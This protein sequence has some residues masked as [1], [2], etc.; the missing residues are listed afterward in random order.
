MHV[1]LVYL[2]RAI[3][4]RAAASSS[5]GRSARLS[6]DEDFVESA[7]DQCRSCRRQSPDRYDLPR[8]LRRLQRSLRRRFS[9]LQLRVHRPRAT[10]SREMFGSWRVTVATLEGWLAPLEKVFN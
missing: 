1:M 5:T 9:S 10:V 7:C 2:P 4:P 6:R 3:L 8:G